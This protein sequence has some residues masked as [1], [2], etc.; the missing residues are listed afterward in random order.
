MLSRAPYTP[1]DPGRTHWKAENTPISLQGHNSGLVLLPPFSSPLKS[2]ED[3][4][5]IG[6]LGIATPCL[7]IT[8]LHFLPLLVKG[9]WLLNK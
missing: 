2:V 1:P 6:G 8:A 4:Y 5:W 7:S 3:L 9:I